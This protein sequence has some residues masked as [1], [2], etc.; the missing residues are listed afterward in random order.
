MDALLSCPFRDTFFST[1]RSVFNER[2]A[3]PDLQRLQ[4]VLSGAARPEDLI[5]DRLRSPFNVGEAIILEELTVKETAQTCQ[6]LAERRGQTAEDVAAELFAHTHGSVYLTQLILERLWDRGAAFAPDPEPPPA[7]RKEIAALAEEI[8]TTAPD[9]IH[10]QNIRASVCSHPEIRRIYRRLV[11]RSKVSPAERERLWF[12]GLAPRETGQLYRNGIYEGAFCRGGSIDMEAAL[13]RWRWGQRGGVGMA[14]LLVLYTLLFGVPHYLDQRALREL[15]EAGFAWNGKD[16]SLVPT[17]EVDITDLDGLAGSLRRVLPRTLILDGCPNLRNIDG[18]R[19]L[20]SLQELS[21]NNCPRLQNV[22]GIN[23]QSSLRQVYV[24]HCKEL[25]NIIG[26]KDL[27][28]LRV[29]NLQDCTSLQNT[30][31]LEGLGYLLYLELN[32]CTGLQEINGLKG[33][34]S[35]TKFQLNG[36]TGLRNIDGF[37]VLSCLRSLDLSGCVGLQNINGLKG[38]SCL[39]GLS[40]D[41]CKSLQNIDALRDL[42]GLLDLDLRGCTGL[43]NFNGLMNLKFLR[44]LYLSEYTTLKNIDALK[45]LSCL[46]NLDLRGCTGLQNIDA[47]KNMS[48]LSKLNLSGCTGLQNIN[49]LKNLSFL[50]E[51]YLD[52]CSNVDHVENLQQ[53]SWL[54]VLSLN[55]CVKIKAE[56]VLNLEKALSKTHIIR[57]DGSERK[58]PATNGPIFLKSKLRQKRSDSEVSL[59]DTEKSELD[60]Q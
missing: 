55:G 58:P 43:R 39:G 42:S 8:I 59:P 44:S 18:L 27:K 20:T 51:L 45:G 15:N 14:V 40:L 30:E 2:S 28:S 16:R 29:L 10:F 12:T 17:R 13:Y 1:L 53:L 7:L 46:L 36:C 37:E 21:L 49:I 33:L 34:R 48:F 9:D 31:A 4:F 5:S 24:T 57:P 6:A 38:L 25:R 54:Y 3:R 35:L 56:E 52:S 50:R 11:F 47:L 60:S 22:N 19:D 26:L 23:G 32:D 41:G